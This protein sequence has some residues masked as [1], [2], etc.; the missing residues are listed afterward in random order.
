MV[1]ALPVVTAELE[2]K[3]S[4]ARRHDWE[5]A[6]KVARK[7]KNGRSGTSNTRVAPLDLRCQID[8][9]IGRNPSK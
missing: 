3:A 9:Q 7:I 1:V 4:L 2:S 6:K 5:V 8:A